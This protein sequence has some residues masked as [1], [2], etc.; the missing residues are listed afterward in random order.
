MMLAPA[1]A[2]SA[3]PSAPPSG[4]ALGCSELPSVGS[5]EHGAGVCKPC[6][7]FHTAGCSNGVACQF[8]HLCDSEEKKRRRKDK[9][10]VKRV[11]GK[12]LRQAD[13]LA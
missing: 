12:A 6:A 3:P 7:F 2:P 1:S 11:A 10:Q 8:C 5:T 4:P 13:S 9:I